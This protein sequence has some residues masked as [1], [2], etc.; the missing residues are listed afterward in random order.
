MP[1]FV[2]TSTHTNQLISKSSPIWTE[3]LPLSRNSFSDRLKEESRKD[4]RYQDYFRA[5]RIFLERN[6]YEKLTGAATFLL[7]RVIT[8]EEIEAIHICLEKHGEFYH[9]ARIEII[10]QG[11][12]IPLVL[13]VAVS[14]NGKNRIE[15]EYNNLKR[16]N[17][18]FS[19]AFLPIVYGRG[20]VLLKDSGFE[21]R[22]F[23][24]EW[25]E[26]FNEFHLSRD[27][28][29]G[30]N[31]IIVWDPVQGN[32]FLSSAQTATLYQQAAKILTCYYNV[33]T[34]EQIFSWH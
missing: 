20:D 10:G 1:Q 30:K 18:K 33:E 17:K 26:G 7:K 15:A 5:A 14:D 32:F 25:F 2:Y 13:N 31:K 11:F 9:P 29:V 23:L 8:P 21:I 24:G 34:F 22:M 27:P 3:P 12:Q 6:H 19:Y 16:L 28:K 4:V